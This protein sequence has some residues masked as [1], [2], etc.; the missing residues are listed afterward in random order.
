[1]LSC[2]IR[3]I[4]IQSLFL[5]TISHPRLLLEPRKTSWRHETK[6]QPWWTKFFKVSGCSS[7]FFSWTSSPE[8][9][10]LNRFMAWERSF[11][12]RIQ[13]IRRNELSWQAR[14]YQI[15][16]AFNCIW[17]LTPVIVTVVSFLVSVM[18]ETTWAYVHYFT[19]LHSCE[20]PTAYTICCLYFSSCLCRIEV[21]ATLIFTII[22]KSWLL[23]IQI[24]AECHV[25]I[26]PDSIT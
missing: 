25:S 17:A 3:L 8:L 15:E 22:S 20:G 19:A 11:E 10:L 18:G 12:S 26:T 6:E 4:H 7:Q 1:M 16:V 14:N 9:T 5:W 21:S 23:M 24:R 13:T 2:Y